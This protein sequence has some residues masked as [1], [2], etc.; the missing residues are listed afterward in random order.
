MIF[1][2]YLHKNVPNFEVREEEIMIARKRQELGLEEEKT[3][4]ISPTASYIDKQRI[5][6]RISGN[7]N[8]RELHCGECAGFKSVHGERSS[9]NSEDLSEMKMS[10]LHKLEREAER[11]ADDSLDAVSFYCPAI[12]KEVTSGFCRGKLVDPKYCRQEECDS[13]SRPKAAGNSNL[14]NGNSKRKSKVRAN[15]IVFPINPEIT[16]YELSRLIEEAVK[17]RIRFP[18]AKT[19]ICPVIDEYVIA[20]YCKAG[21]VLPRHC[22]EHNCKNGKPIELEDD[23]ELRG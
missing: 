14:D 22:K 20:S 1:K 3:C 4:P 10:E 8:S 15:R 21:M 12:G 18:E 2:N 7:D 17:W 16:E 5:C 11:I 13:T 19:F 9:E 23:E 6:A